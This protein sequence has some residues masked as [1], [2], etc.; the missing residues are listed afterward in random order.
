[1]NRRMASIEQEIRKKRAAVYSSASP[2]SVRTCST[3]TSSTV[4]GSKEM[5]PPV[6]QTHAEEPTSVNARTV[7]STATAVTTTADARTLH[8][9]ATA[10]AWTTASV[11]VGEAGSTGSSQDD[12]REQALELAEAQA[13]AEARAHAVAQAQYHSDAVGA[14]SLLATEGSSD[15]SVEPMVAFLSASPL[16]HTLHNGQISSCTSPSAL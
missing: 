4:V 16:V 11:I 1:M 12:A 7:T 13:A 14:A 15:L 8:T 6:L 10:T 9:T 3:E 5:V 2:P